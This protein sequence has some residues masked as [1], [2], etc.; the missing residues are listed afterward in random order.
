MKIRKYSVGYTPHK[1]FLSMISKYKNDI[2]S[3]YFPLPK[4][5]WEVWRAIEQEENY[6]K[7]IIKLIK[8]CSSNS[9]ESI[10]LLNWW[11]E[12]ENTWSKGYVLKII[13][14]MKLLYKEGLT[15]I[16]ISNLVYV[17]I[18]KKIFPKIK[19]YSSVNCTVDT[20]EKALYLKDIWVDIITIYRDI[21]RD[22][23]MIRNIKQKSW[24]KTQIILNETCVR[25][26]MYYE[27]HSN[28]QTHN[29][30]SEDNLIQKYWCTRFYLENKKHF[31]R[32]PFIRP[33]DVYR[34]DSI[35]D[36]YKLSTRWLSPIDISRMLEAYSKQKYDW[37]LL[38][39]LDIYQDKFIRNYI[40]NID[41]NK[42]GKL[43]FF[44]K[45]VKC[46]WDCFT[47]NICN[48]FLE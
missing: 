15:S 11:C 18:I 36:Y 4:S 14:F 30:D 24:L 44:D 28:I 31:F 40:W 23:D 16:S 34:Y 17:P 43:N 25:W 47:C 38:D 22:L 42:L 32:I 2:S 39:L 27:T 37:N 3:V 21:N 29:I 6:I 41:N 7:N 26:C 9:I 19:I 35:V 10:L 13:N 45:I 8:L 1:D 12:W 33:E 20:I 46:Q 5:L 48:N